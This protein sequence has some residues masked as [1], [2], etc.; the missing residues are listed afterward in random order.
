[1]Y[2]C[3]SLIE[4]SEII[5]KAFEKSWE[6]H[7]Q[8]GF[9]VSYYSQCYKYQILNAEYKFNPSNV[10]YKFE[11]KLAKNGFIQLFYTLFL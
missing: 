5:R 6:I 9:Y 7:T 4:G 8:L 1:M 3:G 11:T 10:R 2:V